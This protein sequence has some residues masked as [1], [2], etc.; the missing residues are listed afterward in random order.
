[1]INT[2]F[3]LIID[4]VSESTELDYF[5]HKSNSS[6][7]IGDLHSSKNYLYDF[8]LERGDSHSNF[9]ENI[10]TQ[11]NLLSNDRLK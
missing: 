5:V 9:I 3:D 8:L 7:K 1:M 4:F 11:I 6:L 2:N 10:K